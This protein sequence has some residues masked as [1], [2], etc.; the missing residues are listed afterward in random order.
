MY[1][2]FKLNKL[3]FNLYSLTKTIYLS[4]L[5]AGPEKAM[6]S[7]SSTLAWE[8][9]WTEEP[10]GLQSTGSLRVRHNWATSLSLHTFMHWRRKWQPL[11]CAWRIPGMGEPGGLPSMG[12]HRVGHDWNDLA[13]AAAAATA[14][15]LRE[16]AGPCPEHI[17]LKV[18]R[19]PR[20]YMCRKG[21]LEAQGELCQGLFY[22]DSFSV[23]SILAKRCMLTHGRFLKYTKYGLW[24]RLIKMIGQ[25]KSGRNALY[26]KSYSNCQEG[27]T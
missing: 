2:A 1:S 9:P 16:D 23:K 8:I 3:I 21:S 6:A 19:P 18:R 4:S 15:Q 5:T 27:E 10:G 14:G 25:R 7:H 17:F 24:N 12:S 13:A 11:Q 26:Y 20:P 22:P